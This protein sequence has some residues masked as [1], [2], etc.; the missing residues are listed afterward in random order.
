VNAASEAS[1]LEGKKAI[2]A[3]WQERPDLIKKF[4]GARQYINALALRLMPMINGETFG[5]LTV[6]ATV[7]GGIAWLENKYFTP[8]DWNE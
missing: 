1:R 7:S 5:T 8:R 2:L 6:A 3:T 4:R